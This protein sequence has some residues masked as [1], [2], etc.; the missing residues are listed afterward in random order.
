MLNYL[1]S[2]KLR[3]SDLFLIIWVVFG[4]LIFVDDYNALSSSFSDSIELFF[5]IYLHTI[6]FLIMLIS[7]TQYLLLEHKNVATKFNIYHGIILF[8]L[9]MSELI[10]IMLSPEIIK[11]VLIDIDGHPFD[12]IVSLNNEIKLLHFFALFILVVSFYVGIF[13]F[14]SRFKNKLTIELFIYLY[15]LIALVALIYSLINDDYIYYFEVLTLQKQSSM[16]IKNLCPKSFFGNPNTYG[17]FLEIAFFLSLINYYVSKLKINLILAPIFFTHLF[18]TIC[19]AGMFAST[20]SVFILIIIFAI[21]SIKKINKTKHK[22]I[23]PCI[24]L[25]LASFITLIVLLLIY[26]QN[27]F[28]LFDQIFSFTGRTDIWGASIQLIKQGYISCGWGYGISGSLIS[29]AFVH[30]DVINTPVAHNWILEIL[31][32]GGLIYLFPYCIFLIYAFIKQI[33]NVR[34]DRTNLIIML[35]FLT[36]FLHSFF[37]DISYLVLTTYILYEV[38]NNTDREKSI[39]SI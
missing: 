5:P 1:K 21:S 17:L 27:H 6:F 10:T 24:I 29:N 2:I 37:E 11:L 20:I 33:K 18:L 7:L 22:I 3:L 28:N 36:F 25:L 34:K 4:I 19:K 26:L 14:P 8:V 39:P 12:V 38:K 32:K 31:V 30:Y 16:A 13:I 9:I 15:F 23:I 35:A